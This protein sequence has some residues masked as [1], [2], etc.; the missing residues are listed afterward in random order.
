MEEF[1]NK[2][3]VDQQATTYNYCLGNYYFETGDLKKVVRALNQIE[4]PDL[5]VL[6]SS[7]SLLVKT[8]FELNEV[9]PLLSLIHSFKQLLK[10]KKVLAYHKAN[11]SHF[12]KFITRLVKLDTWDKEKLRKLRMEVEQEKVVYDKEW[13]LKKIDALL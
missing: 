2:M 8:Y 11:Y 1:K 10:R 4:N 12:V 3:S 9:V 6:L 7:K 13:I 5:F